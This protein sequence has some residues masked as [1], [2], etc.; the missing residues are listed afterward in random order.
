M[1]G[2]RVMNFVVCILLLFVDICFHVL[3]LCLCAVVLC[4]VVDVVCRFSLLCSKLSLCV[5]F[6]S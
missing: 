2:L 5:S 6:V 4:F 3:Y 1:F